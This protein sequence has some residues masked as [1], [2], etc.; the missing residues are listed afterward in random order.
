MMKTAVSEGLRFA[1]RA[2]IQHAPWTLGKS[3]VYK[4]F[5][6][7]VGWRPYRATVRTKYGDLMDLTI[8][9][10]VSTTI[11]VTGQWEP[12]ITQYLRSRLRTGDIVV[13]CGSNIGYYSLV[14]SRI[15]GKQG[16]VFA[17][18]ASKC[19]YTRLTTNV[20]LNGYTNVTCIHAA[21]ASEPGEI[22]VF[23]AEA[24]NL[25]HSTTVQ[26]L[27]E[28]E[29][30]EFETKVRADTLEQLVGTDNL[31]KARFVKI[32]VEG[33]ELA[34]LTP[35]L[36]T[37]DQF[38]PRTEW[39]IEL[40]PAYSAGGQ[41]DVDRIYGAFLRAGYTAYKMQNEYRPDF[42]LRPPA[43]PVP[44]R[45]TAPPTELCDVLMSRSYGAFSQ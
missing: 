33:A 19:I 23:L 4:L 43:H 30:M 27:A 28:R 15:V 12:V 45:L 3:S 22:S 14:A 31:R 21:A 38:S 18:E 10:S 41:T 25:G 6:R 11:Y 24:H 1:T 9:D 32:D 34:V 44:R 40:A 2:Y 26:S 42:V 16:R 8:P 7:Y 20:D 36:G 5:N 13:D 37:L 17:I 39:L 29:G 35:L